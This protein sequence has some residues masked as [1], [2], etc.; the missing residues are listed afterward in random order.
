MLLCI[1]AGLSVEE[2]IVVGFVWDYFVVGFTVR[3]GEPTEHAMVSS[4][5]V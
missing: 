3:G 4:F 5:E 2:E 1:W